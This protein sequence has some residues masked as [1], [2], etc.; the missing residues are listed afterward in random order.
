MRSFSNW[1]NAHQDGL[2][3]M[4]VCIIVIV[5]YLAKEK[6]KKIACLGMGI[7]IFFVLYKTVL[8]RTQKITTVNLE[9]GWSYKALTRGVRG[10]FS[11]I[12]LNIILFV[13]IGVFGGILFLNKKKRS[14]ILPIILGMIV[15]MTVEYLQLTLQCGT[16]ELDDILNNMIGTIVGVFLAA[17]IKRNKQG[18]A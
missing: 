15:T 9:L 1:I 2:A 11:Q 18:M 17:I 3:L 5:V 10:M 7:Y 4:V 14:G 8:S 12:Y 13:P 16:F 6:R